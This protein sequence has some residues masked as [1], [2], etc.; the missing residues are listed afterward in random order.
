MLIFLG[1]ETTIMNILQS[2]LKSNHLYVCKKKYSKKHVRHLRRSTLN[3][4]P[5]LDSEGQSDE[6]RQPR[7]DQQNELQNH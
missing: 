3:L 1:A 7:S 2:Q 4:H 5:P 6:T